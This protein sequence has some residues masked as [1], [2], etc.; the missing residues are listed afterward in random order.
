MDRPSLVSLPIDRTTD[1]YNEL[2]PKTTPTF[3]IL[4]VTKHAFTVLENRIPGTISFYGATPLRRSINQSH[5]SK[6][7]TTSSNDKTTIHETESYTEKRITP[8]TQRHHQGDGIINHQPRLQ[9]YFLKKDS[10]VIERV[11]SF[12]KQTTDLFQSAETD[13]V[14][15]ELVGRKKTPKERQQKICRHGYNSADD[16]FEQL[17]KIRTTL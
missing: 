3:P 14:I 11:D 6:A 12:L 17:A 4:Q 5:H 7:S 1:R 10:S 9:K 16:T 13:Y 8:N 15:D 2:L